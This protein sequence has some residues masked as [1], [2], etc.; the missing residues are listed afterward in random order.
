VR[1]LSKPGLAS[2]AMA[3]LG[4]ANV[5]SGRFGNKLTV[6]AV[7]AESDGRVRRDASP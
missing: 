3:A 5:V 6:Q 1:A 4:A 2:I 7:R